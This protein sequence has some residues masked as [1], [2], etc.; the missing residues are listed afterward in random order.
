MNILYICDEYPPAKSGGIGSAVKIVAEAM[1]SLGHAV[2]VLGGYM[3]YEK[4]PD[5]Q[6]QNGVHVYR[7]MYFKQMKYIFAL[8]TYLL[9]YAILRKLKVWSMIAR[10]EMKKFAN[11]INVFV[12][13]HNIEIIEFPDYTKLL[14]QYLDANFLSF[15]KFRVPFIVRVHGSPVFLNYY[16]KRTN[17]QLAIK[18]ISS[19]YKSADKILAVS[20]F[21]AGFLKKE[22]HIENQIDV[23]YNPVSFEDT[24]I[25]TS[26]KDK[27]IVFVGKINE[28]KGAFNL[29]AAFNFFALKYPNYKLLMIGGG[30][31][32]KGKQLL[33]SF[34][35]KKVI[36]TGYVTHSQVTQYVAKAE[37]CV[38]PSFFETQGLAA[39]ETM[40]LSKALIFTQTSSGPELVEHEESGLLVNPHNVHDICTAMV[41]LATDQALRIKLE[42]NAKMTVE[43]RFSINV[44]IEQLE[45]AYKD[46]ITEYV[47]SSG[48]TIK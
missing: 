34:A 41:R 47:S 43:K 24:D 42:T 32:K 27:W 31:I 9:L 16:G 23:I 5:Y 21:A 1:A 12:E 25:T 18:N 19:L 44:I 22:L 28:T 36:F 30:D 20:H 26:E 38:M 14:S 15:P 2:Y 40:H 6:Y 8:D 10:M 48:N 7:C 33:S 35:E 13:K 3:P 29:L 17:T 45:S 11:H 39:I 46:C 4:L 37:F